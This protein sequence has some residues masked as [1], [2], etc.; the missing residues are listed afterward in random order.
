MIVAIGVSYAWIDRSLCE[1]IYTHGLRDNLL[2]FTAL[3]EWPP[4]MSGLAPLML[5]VAS[6]L[7]PGRQRHLLILVGL[8]VLMTFVLKND[9][10]WIF[11]RYWPMTWTHQNLSWIS[12]RAYGFQ[13]FQGHLFQGND[14]TGSFPSGHAAVAFAALL[15][16]GIVYRKLMGVVLTVAAVEALS[17]V[18]YDYHFLSDILAGSLVG[19]SCVLLVDRLLSR[20]RN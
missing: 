3:F 2:P 16:V 6:I 8:S 20:P 17:M 9:L 5:M 15:P 14:Q 11:S 10:K 12:H 4:L 13:W 18:A 19:I 1:W 7:P